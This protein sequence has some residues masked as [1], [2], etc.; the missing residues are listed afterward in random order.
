MKFIYVI[1]PMCMFSACKQS[2]PSTDGK[3]DVTLEVLESARGSENTK[4]AEEGLPE[5]KSKLVGDARYL[6]MEKGDA[7]AFAKKEG[8]PSRIVS[9]DGK[10]GMM[11]MDYR[12]ERLN[13]TVVDGKITKVTRG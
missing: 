12:P 10:T 11:T 4:T 2:P 5:S 8:S 13:F 6:G 9:E 7:A 1:I 3:G